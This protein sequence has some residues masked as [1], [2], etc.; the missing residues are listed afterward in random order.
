MPKFNIEKTIKSAQKIAEDTQEELT[1]YL[2]ELGDPNRRSAL[3]SDH[4]AKQL[5]QASI[6]AQMICNVLGKILEN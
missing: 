1:A 4:Y 3:E 6:H 2:D 5:E